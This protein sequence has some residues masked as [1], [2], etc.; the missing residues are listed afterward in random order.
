MR[1]SRMLKPRLKR[2]VQ[3]QHLSLMGR[4]LRPAD[5]CHGDNVIHTYVRNPS[6]LAKGRPYLVNAVSF[7]F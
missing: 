6:N 3:H 1:L 7:S 2:T 4:G 5:L